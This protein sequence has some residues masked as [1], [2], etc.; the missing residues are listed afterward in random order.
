VPLSFVTALLRLALWIGLTYGLVEGVEFMLLG[1]VPGALAWRTGNS[2][3][4]LWVAPLVYGAAFLLLAGIIGLPARF[5]PRIEWDAVLLAL[6]VF[7]AAYFAFSLQGQLFSSLA[8]AA[9]ALGVSFQLTRRYRKRR[10][11]WERRVRKTLPHLA[12]FILV[13]ALTT[14]AAGRLREWLS[15]RSLPASA[16]ESPNVLLIVL[17]AL[18][19]D[20][21]SAYGYARRTTPRLDRL[22]AEGLLFENAYANSSWTLP[23]HASFFTG[24]FVHEH[25]AGEPHLPFL[26]ARHPTLA[27][28]LRARGYRTA[29]FVANTFWCGRQTGLNRGFIRY[30]DFF[31]NAADAAT[32]TV[33][34]RR[35][36]YDVLPL[37]GL[38]DIPGRKRAHDLNGDLLRWLEKNDGRPF[39][40]FLNY[41]DVHGP[42]LPPRG[43]RGLFSG[44]PGAPHGGGRPTRQPRTVRLGAVTE[45]TRVP[46]ARELRRWVDAYDESLAYLDAE[47][48]R[49]LDELERRG[50]LDDTVVIVTSDH[51]ESF[52]EHDLIYHG[53]S[54]YREQ[55]QVPLILRYPRRIVP[56]TRDD[57]PAGLERLPST[58]TDLLGWDEQPFPGL[59]LAASD[60]NPGE[61][62]AR[63]PIRPPLAGV[64][65][66]VGY[67]TG[68]PRSWPTAQGW[69]KS[70]VTRRWH[71]LLA[72]DGR[73]ELYDLVRDPKE[74]TNLAGSG[75]MSALESAFRADLEGTLSR[76][77]AFSQV[78]PR[79]FARRLRE[80]LFPTGNVQTR[81]KHEA[82]SP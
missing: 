44:E 81:G 21:V 24:R 4:V 48:G 3:P 25:H 39:F 28:V 54:L 20:H 32:R 23:S 2:A 70:L 73:S 34:G 31:G 57:R 76:A 61:T 14:F 13:L 63:G 45:E 60:R 79:E 7:L 38:V 9:L 62:E 80:A 78:A 65:S 77:P 6:L 41:L 74:T 56:G 51:G 55:L 49:L 69:I 18:R 42:Y 58:V 26:D 29:G 37:L 35:L 46:E 15:T 72:E 12:A 53:H 43:Y 47:L 27:E 82:V 40:A 66:Q 5:L 17:D 71:F 1:F 64:L 75:Q 36:S 19:A 59:S 52:G 30:E 10:G 50:L 8:S 16:A 11:A 22:A 33:L 67:R 68:V